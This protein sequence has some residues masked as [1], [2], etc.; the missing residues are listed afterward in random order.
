M[1]QKEFTS[2]GGCVHEMLSK[3]GDSATYLVDHH[4]G[5]K[6]RWKKVEYVTQFDSIWVNYAC[7]KFEMMGLLCKHAL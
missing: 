2:S 3:Y 5:E 1:F 6:S 4:N 7:A